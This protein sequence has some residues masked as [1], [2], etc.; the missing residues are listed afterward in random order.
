[1]TVVLFARTTSL[2]RFRRGISAPNLRRRMKGGT[3]S[4]ILTGC[5]VEQGRQAGPKEITSAICSNAPRAVASEQVGCAIGAHPERRRS[6]G[7][8]EA[9]ASVINPS[10]WPELRSMV[11][12]PRLLQCET[13]TRK[14]ATVLPIG[15]ILNPGRR[16]PPE[17][18]CVFAPDTRFRKTPRFQ[19]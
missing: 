17:W 16:N 11:F 15:S 6:L 10:K 8:L 5:T 3:A 13:S 7:T 12:L 9:T 14:S 4:T 2:A 19:G 1:V 18:S